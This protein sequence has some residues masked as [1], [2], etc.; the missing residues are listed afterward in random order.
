[1]AAFRAILRA[2]W[3]GKHGKLRQPDRD[4]PADDPSAA[5]PTLLETLGAAAV[6]GRAAQGPKAGAD[7]VRSGRGSRQEPFQRRLL[8]AE[9]DGF[10]LH[11]AVRVPAGCRAQL[12]S[13][14]LLGREASGV[15]HSHLSGG[16]SSGVMWFSH[17][18]QS[19]SLQIA[20]RW[21]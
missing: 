18:R 11:A 9:C 21:S 3:L 13:I 8:T 15:S 4:G 10:S 19:K 1:V 7:D 20:G 5:E 17:S 16:P 6:Q 2:R 14:P 12:A